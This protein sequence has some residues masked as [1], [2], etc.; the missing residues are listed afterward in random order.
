MLPSSAARLL[1]LPGI[2]SSHY[3]DNGGSNLKSKTLPLLL[4]EGGAL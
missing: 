1:L 2:Y 4:A 3:W